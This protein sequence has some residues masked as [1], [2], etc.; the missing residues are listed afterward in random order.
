MPLPAS[1][2]LAF[3]NIK[4]EF[5]ISTS[6][7][8]ISSQLAPLIGQPG[9]TKRVQVSDFYSASNVFGN[10]FG[11]AGTGVNATTDGPR[12]TSQFSYPI[13]ITADVPDGVLYIMGQYENRMRKI[14]LS[15]NT[16]STL[17]T[18]VPWASQLTRDNLSNIY[19]ATRDEQTIRRFDL[20]TN[21]ST[22]IAG[23]AGSTGSADG[24]GAAARFNLPTG[25]VYHDSNLYVSDSDNHK[26]R[27]VTIPGAVV[28]T[29]AGSGT[30]TTSNGIGTAAS[31]SHPQ[32]LAV[33]ST[34]ATANLYV[35]EGRGRCIRRIELQT[36]NVTTFAGLPAV[37]GGGGYAEGT[38]V[39][40]LFN[41]MS[42]LCY[43]SSNLYVGDT[44]NTVVRRVT[45]PGAVVSTLAG[46]PP[47]GYVE[48]VGTAAKF[49]LPF[50]LTYY[51]GYVFVCDHFNS[52]IR[53]IRVT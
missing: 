3:S 30:D 42:G 25:I 24:T 45:V 29:F 26:I 49:N 53:K 4:T 17:A 15:T 33:D 44:N 51:S 32:N 14:D 13:G 21:T 10:T 18:G 5:S 19:I 43:A 41:Y 23:T 37:N 47:S 27:R 1:G 12:I 8:S 40:A 50:G 6:V 38:G 9:P 48:G 22:I 52:R 31:F 11:Y 16:V 35:C 7:N 2:L 20:V 28:T 36:A 46:Q 39:A 34:S